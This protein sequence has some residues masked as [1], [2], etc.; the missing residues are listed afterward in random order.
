ML[1]DF[2]RA[3]SAWAEKTKTLTRDADIKKELENKL[4]VLVSSEYR[5]REDAQSFES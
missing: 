3:T 5:L 1:N 2:E 4:N